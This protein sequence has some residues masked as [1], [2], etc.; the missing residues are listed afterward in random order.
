MFSCYLSKIFPYCG[1]N[2][3]LASIIEEEALHSSCLFFSL[4]NNKYCTDGLIDQDKSVE[5]NNVRL[6]ALKIK[7]CTVIW[8]PSLT[9]TSVSSCSFIKGLWHDSHVKRW[10]PQKRLGHSFQPHIIPN[11]E[12]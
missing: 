3:Y 4:K 12:G 5:T 6:G 7:T 8:A 9:C 1:Q 10:F 11:K 2:H